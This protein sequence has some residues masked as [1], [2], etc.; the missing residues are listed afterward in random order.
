M[1]RIEYADFDDDEKED[2]EQVC[3]QAGFDPAQFT[4]YADREDF[5]FRRGQHRIDRMVIVV[6]DGVRVDL[7]GRRWVAD[8]ADKIAVFR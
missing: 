5:P 6:K 3:H 8:F 4:I 1:A 7:D 2:F